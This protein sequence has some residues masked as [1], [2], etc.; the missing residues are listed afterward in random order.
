MLPQVAFCT[1]VVLIRD[2]FANSSLIY[3]QLS[4]PF[5]FYRCL[6]LCWVQLFHLLFAAEQPVIKL[7]R[8]KVT[9]YPAGY[10][11]LE[12]PTQRGAQQVLEMFNG[13]LIRTD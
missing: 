9:G 12:F 11:F 13:Q 6:C 4:L 3:R 2:L 7:I 8:D 5:Y 10:G 1:C